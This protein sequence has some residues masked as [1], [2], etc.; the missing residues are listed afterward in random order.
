MTK[1]INVTPLG[2][3][4]PAA[5]KRLGVSSSTMRRLV[6]AG[7]FAAKV[8]ASGR[9]LVDAAAIDAYHAALPDYVP[10]TLPPVARTRK[11]GNENGGA[12]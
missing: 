9:I 5:A 4:M 11:D 12:A 2:L 6:N 7:V 1:P 8:T 3:L 10:G